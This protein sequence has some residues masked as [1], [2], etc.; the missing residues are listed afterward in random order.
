MSGKWT[1]A[2]LLAASITAAGCDD[3]PSYF[4]AT[5][6][7]CEGSRAQLLE[8]I[9]RNCGA[10]KY[11]EDCIW[12]AVKAICAPVWGFSTKGGGGDWMP[13]TQAKTSEQIA[14][15]VSVGARGEEG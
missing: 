8:Q 12:P 14:V 1:K 2:L 7:V 15:C 10:G 5:R 11:P 3:K 9:T 13:C 4:A 6:H